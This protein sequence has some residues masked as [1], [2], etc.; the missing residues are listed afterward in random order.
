MPTHDRQWLFLV[1]VGFIGS[2]ALHPHEHAADAKPAGAVVAGQHRQRGGVHVHHLVFGIVMMMVAG[3]ISFAGFAVSPIYEICAVFF[4]IGIGLTI[5]EFALWVHLDDVY[6]A[7]D[8]RRSIDATMIAAAGLVLILLGVRPFEVDDGS[9]AAVLASVALLLF[10]FAMVAICFYKQRMLHGLIGFLI[11]PLALYGACRIG[12]PESPWA[13][14]FY[15]ERNP[16]KQ[17]KAERRFR[18]AVAPTGSRRPP[19]TRSA[20]RPPTS[21]RRRSR[22]G[23]SA[24]AR[25]A[26]A[27]RGPLRPART[28]V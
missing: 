24:P 28:A 14:R 15:G 21:T 2:F 22:T 6:W 11:P 5:D 12:K 18:P 13:R 17:A 3:T 4:G 19:A 7:E 27:G 26:G 16:R 25:L 8:G 1:L 10:H 20:A 9:A 23:A